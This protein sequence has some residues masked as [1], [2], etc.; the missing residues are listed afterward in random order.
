MA[1]RDLFRS[2]RGPQA[3]AAD[4]T[5]RAGGPAYALEPKHALAQLVSTSC[6][7]GTYY[8]TAGEHLDDLLRLA[9]AVDPAFVA[10]AAVHARRRGQ[11]AGRRSA[12]FR[13]PGRHHRRRQQEQGKIDQALQLAE[14]LQRM[15]VPL[16]AGNHAAWRAGRHPASGTGDAA[17][18][19]RPAAAGRHAAR[20]DPALDNPA[21][22]HR[23]RA[24]ALNPGPC[25]HVKTACQPRRD[26]FR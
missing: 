26:R 15:A 19:A 8:A 23:L 12:A 1:L 22:I 21:V 9:G 7:A 6:V 13:R 14:P 20:T 2:F 24:C 5:N 11:R 17:W 18:P 16:H 4:A 3:P 10:K 25:N